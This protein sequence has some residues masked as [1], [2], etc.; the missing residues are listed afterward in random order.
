MGRYNARTTTITFQDTDG[1]D[2]ITVGPGEGDFTISEVNQSNTEITRV[3]NRGVFDGFVKGDDLEQSWSITVQIKTE[4]LTDAT[5]ARIWDFVNKSGSF[6][7][8]NAVS[9]D[10]W[11]WKAIV[12]MD[13]GTTTATITLPVCQG[14]LAFSEGKEFHT[15]SLSGTNNGKPTVT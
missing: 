9:P 7:S 6:A 8:A 4:N 1:S 11:S 15:F 2:T 3:L 10:A 12:T 14:S 13:D 5:H